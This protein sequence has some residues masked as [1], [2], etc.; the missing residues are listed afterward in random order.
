MKSWRAGMFVGR[1]LLT[2]SRCST[3]CS[4]CRRLGTYTSRTCHTWRCI[5]CRSTRCTLRKAREGQHGGERNEK[6][7]AETA[8]TG[9]MCCAGHCV[10]RARLR[11]EV[12]IYR[13]RTV[14]ADGVGG[15]KEQR[16]SEEELRHCCGGQIRRR[17]LTC[18][19]RPPA[20][21]FWSF[22]LLAT[23][24]RGACGHRGTHCKGGESRDCVIFA[25]RSL[26]D[27]FAPLA[28]RDRCARHV[29]RDA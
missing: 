7:R 2:Y 28:C 13:Q 24:A 6:E 9:Q 21:I 19:R 1:R 5:R 22:L 29:E 20:G 16:Q 14:P 10:L 12:E 26:F 17:A 25:G 18:N 15:A 27:P 11:P 3:R 23:A 4:R 8:C